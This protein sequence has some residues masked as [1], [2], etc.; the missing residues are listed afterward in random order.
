MIIENSWKLKSLNK[1]L[2]LRDGELHIWRT[3]VS[4]N[5]YNLEFYWNLLSQDEQVRAKEFYFVRDRNRYIIA[6]GILR[7]LI[8][9]YAGITPENILF[10]YTE[11]GKPYLAVNND[12]SEIKFNLAHSKDSIVYA[13]TQNIDVGIDIEF[14]NKDFVMEDVVNYCCSKQEQSIL[15]KLSRFEKHY[16]FY[17]L[18]VIKEALVKA[19]GIG[20]SYDLR[21][22]HINFGK[23]K[24]INPINIINND[25]INWTTDVFLSYNDYY[26]AFAVKN[27]MEKVFFFTVRE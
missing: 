12:F 1:K 15:Q 8:A 4:K 9:N 18:W 11:Y 24:L 17:K 6:R 2:T 3:K 13:F 14:I 25:K 23:N 22:I 19:M 10:K 27:Q 5:E 21:Q 7:S 16:Y 20:L 26:S